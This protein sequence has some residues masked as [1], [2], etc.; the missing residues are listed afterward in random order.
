MNF[1]NGASLAHTTARIEGR[2][3]H[4]RTNRSG[5]LEAAD[6][7]NETDAGVVD[8]HASRVSYISH[9]VSS[10]TSVKIRQTLARKSTPI[11]TIGIYAKA[12]LHDIKGALESLPDLTGDKPGPEALQMTGTGPHS[13]HFSKQFATFWPRAGD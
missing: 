1:Y 4:P 5:A 9:L 3:M 10:G 11:P 12:S 6:V 7:P 13:R 2:S 8:F